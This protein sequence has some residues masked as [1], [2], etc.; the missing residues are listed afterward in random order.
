[1]QS[2]ARRMK[3]GTVGVRHLNATKNKPGRSRRTQTIVKSRFASDANQQITFTI[4]HQ[5]CA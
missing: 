1:M 4:H 5:D 3:R 2:F